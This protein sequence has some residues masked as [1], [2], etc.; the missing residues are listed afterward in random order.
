MKPP[1][2]VR[3]IQFTGVLALRTALH[4]GSSWGEGSASDSPVIRT[5]DGAP[6]I[7]GS[8]F[9]GAFRS[10]VEKMALTAGLTSCGL[11]E[12]NGCIGAQGKEMDAFN[13]L[14]RDSSWSGDR[15]LAELD[16]RLCDT[17]QLFGSQYAASRIF[18]S[19][20][21]PPPEDKLAASMIQVRDGVAIDRDSE[22]AV[23]RLK[24]DYEVVA[25]AQTFLL[26]ILLELP[27]DE[28]AA[29][30]EQDAE[31]GPR[32]HRYDLALTCLGVSEYV[33]GFGRIG[34]KKSRGLGACDLRSLA[35]Y[36]LDLRPDDPVKRAEHLHRYLLGRTPQEKMTPVP[37]PEAFLNEQI[38]TLPIFQEARS[39][40]E[41]HAEKAL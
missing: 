7:P 18:F 22:K 6:F 14:R 16:A 31:A 41:D 12:G 39:S 1:A 33:S 29:Q 38:Q 9:K 15:Y 32:P 3:R 37:D 13:K 25:P 11:L 40:G 28:E 30:Q 26:N 17:C 36:E 5:P 34:G 23:D 35:I 27:Q 4:V 19:D 20:L 2:F 21:L 10:T 8:S 24:Y